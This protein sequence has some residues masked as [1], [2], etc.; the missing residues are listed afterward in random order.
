MDTIGVSN[1]GVIEVIEDKK[2]KFFIGVE[3]HPETNFLNKEISK[4]LF[5]AFFETVRNS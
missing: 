3:W 4:K 1:D 5:N 2:K